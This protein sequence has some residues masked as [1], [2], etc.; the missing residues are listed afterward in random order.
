MILMILY[1]YL[2]SRTSVDRWRPMV[3]KVATGQGIKEKINSPVSDDHMF[4]MFILGNCNSII[5]VTPSKQIHT[6]KQ[7]T[8]V[9]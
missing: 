5:E 4:I 9:A 7:G 2:K 1:V 8:K 3:V 6:S